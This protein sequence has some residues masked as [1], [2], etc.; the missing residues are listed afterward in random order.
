MMKDPTARIA[1]VVRWGDYRLFSVETPEMAGRARP[2]QF[3]MIKVSSQPDPLLRRP[4][5]IHARENGRLEIFF[6]V[7]GRGTEIMA[8]RVPGTLST[9]SALWAKDS[10][11]TGV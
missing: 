3:L 7:T 10:P 11:W 1:N 6:R 2:G 4:F 9:S 5:S 8:K